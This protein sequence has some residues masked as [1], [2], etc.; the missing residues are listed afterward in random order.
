MGLFRCVHFLD[1]TRRRCRH[2]AAICEHR[3]RE[4]KEIGHD[5]EDENKREH[6][7]RRHSLVSMM[8]ADLK[9]GVD[10]ERDENKRRDHVI[11]EVD[12]VF[13]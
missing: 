1:S 11:D 13:G 5:D 8:H 10:R 2:I 3:M 12:N 7:T 6:K 9:T 4:H